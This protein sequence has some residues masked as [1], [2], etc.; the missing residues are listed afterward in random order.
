MWNSQLLYTQIYICDIGDWLDSDMKIN[1]H[2][3]GFI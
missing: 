2:I 1:F 3:V